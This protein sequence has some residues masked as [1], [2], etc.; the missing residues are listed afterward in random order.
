MKKLLTSKFKSL[1]LAGRLFLVVLVVIISMTTLG[2]RVN[3]QTSLDYYRNL[4]RSW[5][6]PVD[7][8]KSDDVSQPSTKKDLQT[9][10]EQLTGGQK[11]DLLADDLG[12]D[13]EN[14]DS[15]SMAS[16]NPNNYLLILESQQDQRRPTY[17]KIIVISKA[18]PVDLNPN[19]SS[20]SDVV[21]QIVKPKVVDG[22]SYYQ[23]PEVLLTSPYYQKTVASYFK[24]V[25]KADQT[26][27]NTKADQ[28]K[29]GD[30]VKSVLTNL[31]DSS[32]AESFFYALAILIFVAVT[33]LPLKKLVLNPRRY[34]EK[35][36]YTTALAKIINAIARNREA[37]G[38][39][40]A[41]LALFYIP[42]LYTLSVKA[43]ALGDP[44]Y[45][46]KY[47]TTT[48]NPVNIPNYLTSQNLFRVG[49]LFYHYTLALFGLFLLLPNLVF[50][51]AKS[52]DK[53]AGVRLKIGFVKWTVP[54][55]I[56]F[57]SILLMFFKVADLLSFLTLGSL[58][59]VS[60]VAYVKTRQLDLQTLYTTKEKRIIFAGLA[61]LL[62][63]NVVYPLYSKSRPVKYAYEPLIGIKDEV[64]AFPYSKKWGEHVLFEPHYYNG[65]SLVFAD[66]YL[67]FAPQAQTVVNKPLKDFASGDSFVITAKD[68]DKVLE[69]ALKKN[70]PATGTTGRMRL[71]D[72]LTTSNFS[73][74]FAVDTQTVTKIQEDFNSKVAAKLTFNCTL[75]PAPAT[76]K[77][78]TTSLNPFAE[79]D[80]GKS[81]TNKNLDNNDNPN[82]TGSNIAGENYGSKS[83]TRE[84]GTDI[85]PLTKESTEVLNF[86]GCARDTG[87]ETFDFP[88]DPYIFPQDGFV[89][90]IRGID[91]KYIQN[92]QLFVAQQEL[93]VKFLAKTILDDGKYAL[94]YQSPQMGKTITAYSTEVSK[95]F[96][97]DLTA[98][99][100]SV[101]QNST[102]KDNATKFKSTEYAYLLGEPENA[103]YNISNPIN[104]L[105]KKGR[106]KNPFLIWTNKPYEL[107]RMESD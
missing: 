88:L 48:L 65:D 51:G 43:R 66:G 19:E 1:K 77:L 60:L 47:I 8:I 105:M 64:V 101:D 38:L 73:P 44:T 37:L 72:Y 6:V 3:A 95:E 104:E 29:P 36:F 57:M 11:S 75:K 97:V 102:S 106:L 25:A 10:Y 18:S 69:I 99:N 94:L 87:T 74:L 92:L 59:L 90:R 31:K 79:N 84:E 45:P 85:D 9:L 16:A 54:V 63:L 82:N 50:L 2:R 23:I 42:I 33:Y 91:D 24:A 78:E 26:T 96:T 55:V 52:T 76:V 67:L 15:A 20:S 27:N 56:A 68:S 35:S 22:V 53:F 62:V 13:V 46:V 17:Q 5:G 4:F 80:S 34:L 71:M 30:K 32:T 49:L 83:D 58:I 81:K 89:G 103:G 100:P 12:K 41:I 70:G 93:P 98:P 21:L 61:L 7:I 28:K 107:I 86:P 39:I 40:F 14:D